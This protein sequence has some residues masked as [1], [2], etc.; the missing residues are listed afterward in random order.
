MLNGDIHRKSMQTLVSVTTYS[1]SKLLTNEI[2]L[3][4]QQLYLLSLLFGTNGIIKS[5]RST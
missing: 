2:N 3:L 1:H 4:S 5:N